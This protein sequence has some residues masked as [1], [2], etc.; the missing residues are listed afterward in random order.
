[1]EQ[2]VA[3]NPRPTGASSSR[4]AILRAAAKSPWLY[5]VVNEIGHVGAIG[6]TS[7]GD[8]TV[9]SVL[10]AVI[11]KHGL[12]AKHPDL[13]RLTASDIRIAPNHRNGQPCRESI[14]CLCWRRVLFDDSFIGLAPHFAE[15]TYKKET[16]P[17]SAWSGS[18][19]AA[20]YE[21]TAEALQKYPDDKWRPIFDERYGDLKTGR[22]ILSLTQAQY[23]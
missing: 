20:D 8:N 7:D 19:Y 21:A 2:L 1:L 5:L 4:I 13:E 15:L 6:I 17:L 9:N 18:T 23:Y 12:L 16:T 22:R 11:D 14:C 10:R 3:Q